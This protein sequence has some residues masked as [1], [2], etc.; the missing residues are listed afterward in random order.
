MDTFFKTVLSTRLGI[1]FSFLLSCMVCIKAQYF[2]VGM[3]WE[4][5]KV[6]PGFEA[7]ESTSRLFEISTD[8]VIDN[9]SYRK[10]LVN[11]KDN[12]VCIHERGEKVWLHDC[13]RN[14][15]ILLYDFDWSKGLCV[16]TEH[17]EKQE[18]G[19]CRVVS[20]TISVGEYGTTHYGNHDWQYYRN[21][22]RSIIRGI[23]AVAELN[24]NASLLGYIEPSPI[25]PG[26][27][28]YKVLW[29]R[30][31]GKEIF[32]S[33]NPEDWTMGVPT[34]IMPLAI[35]N[36]LGPTLIDLQGRTVDDKRHKMRDAGN[37]VRKGVYIRDGRKVVV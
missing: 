27:E 24:R 36:H 1:T 10:V 32:R 12:G 21:G 22:N 2:P 5:T 16:V 18:N 26:L 35:Q 31:E 33:E 30:R 11:G 23:G 17:L 15:E 7:F 20:D 25:L 8:T 9:T 19:N 4:E 14:K 34:N 37:G 29:I 28:Y 3:T 13:D 6:S